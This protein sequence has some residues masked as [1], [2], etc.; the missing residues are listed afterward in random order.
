MR[1]WKL[2]RQLDAV[3]RALQ[4]R[5]YHESLDNL[6]AAS[7]EPRLFAQNVNARDTIANRRLQHRL[8]AA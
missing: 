5:R 3:V 2:E 1:S 8:Q 6:T 7:A 4:L